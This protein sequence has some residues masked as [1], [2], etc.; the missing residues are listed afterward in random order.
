MLSN[1]VL[2]KYTH[3]L[4]TPSQTFL[5]SLNVNYGTKTK[6]I[7]SY[8]AWSTEIALHLP[9]LRICITPFLHKG[10]NQAHLSLLFLDISDV[11]EQL[12]TFFEMSTVIYIVLV[13]WCV[14][15]R[16]APTMC[17]HLLLIGFSCD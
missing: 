8:K 17:N 16:C 11:F 13:F 4:Q 5:G 9:S 2:L 1:L 10:S 7:R 15:I 3:C 6:E 12:K 14:V